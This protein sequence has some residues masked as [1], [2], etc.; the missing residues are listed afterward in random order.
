MMAYFSQT[1]PIQELASICINRVRSFILRESLAPRGLMRATFSQECQPVFK[2]WLA[3]LESE[4]HVS[5]LAPAAWHSSA[6]FR[7]CVC[8]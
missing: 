3:K 7:A 4:K 1:A 5:A 2:L 6:P 8:F